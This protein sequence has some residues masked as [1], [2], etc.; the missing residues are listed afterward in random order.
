MRS[1]VFQTPGGKGMFNAFD[2]SSPDR[3]GQ[4]LLRRAERDRAKTASV[5]P[6]T[7]RGVDFLLG[8]RDDIRQGAIRFRKPGSGDYFSS[9]ENAVPKVIELSRLLQAVDRYDAGA[10]QDHDLKGN[11]SHGTVLTVPS[12]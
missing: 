8:V 4:N 5:T 10:P 1:G 2:D 7:L 9:H 6:R 11:S 12:G 3:W